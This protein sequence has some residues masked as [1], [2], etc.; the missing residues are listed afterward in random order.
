MMDI[1]ISAIWVGMS[2]GIA[3]AGMVTL[4]KNK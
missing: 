3:I 4:A 2:V 1:I